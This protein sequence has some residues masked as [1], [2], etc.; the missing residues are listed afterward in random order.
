M[1]GTFSIWYVGV[2]GEPLLWEAGYT[3]RQLRAALHAVRSCA[4]HCSWRTTWLLRR[5]RKTIARL[6]SGGRPA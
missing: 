6:A 3:R 1:R 4:H 5:E 2:C